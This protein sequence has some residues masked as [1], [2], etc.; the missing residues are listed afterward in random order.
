MLPILAPMA[1][2]AVGGALMNKKK[3]LNGALLGAGRRRVTRC[4]T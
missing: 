3:P 1:I 2:G 4:R